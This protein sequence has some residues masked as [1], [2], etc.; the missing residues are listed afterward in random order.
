VRH[1]LADRGFQE[2]INFAFVPEAWEQDFTA[3]A[4]PIRLANPIASQLAVMRSNLFGGLIENLAVNLKR[5][6]SR[7]R[8]FELG[9]CFTQNGTD[10]AQPWRLAA[11]AYGTAQ[12]EGWG[13]ENRKV[14]F[15][16]L[17][18]DLQSLFAAELSF[19]RPEQAHPALH[20]GRAASIKLAGREIGYLGELHPQWAQKYDLPAAPVVFEI[21][22]DAVTQ[23]AIPAYAEVS[24]FQPAV[25]DLAIVVDQSLALED[26]LKGM[27][28]HAPNQVCDIQLFDMYQGKGIPDGRKSLAFRIVMQDTQRTLL[29]ADIDAAVVKITTYLEQNFQAQLRA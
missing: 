8:L 15:F 18:A 26:I 11:L 21:D 14:D 19:A 22:L 29:D 5:K 10:Y 13:R 1:Q 7:V 4:R 25:R 9:R 12:P 17:K 3:N 23:V 28:A 6:Q 20:P 16:D 24:K 27:K 2:V